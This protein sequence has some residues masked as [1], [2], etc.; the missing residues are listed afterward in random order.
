MIV[1]GE[2]SVV[3]HGHRRGSGLRQCVRG[4]AVQDS[5]IAKLLVGVPAHSHTIWTMICHTS[6]RV[7][8]HIVRLSTGRG[9]QGARR[10][11]GGPE[12]GESKH[13]EKNNGVE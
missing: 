10:S 3:S 11:Y 13:D 9:G 7:E 12:A 5:G 4:K 6:L 8:R 2:G 1:V